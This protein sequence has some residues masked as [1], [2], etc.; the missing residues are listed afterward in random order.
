[1]KQ[2][3]LV[4]LL[5]IGLFGLFFSC[6]NDVALPEDPID[7]GEPCDSSIVY[8]ALDVLPIF[9]ANCAFSGCHDAQ[10][11]AEGVQ[12]DT[13]VNI[14]TTGDV[15]PNKPN[16]SKVYELIVA[17]SGNKMPPEPYQRLGAQQ[18]S[19]IE[20]WIN[21]GAKNLTCTATGSCDT[22][23]VSYATNITP[24]LS[25]SCLSCHAAAVYENVGGGIDLSSYNAVRTVALNGRLYGSVSHSPDYQAMP[26]GLSQ[27]PSCQI[28]QIKAWVDAGAP[29]N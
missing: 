14:M 16:K 4:L 21:Q 7:T 19:I 27:L 2:N 12:L 23:N 6:T 24:I 17:T 13:Y 15:Q 28:K 9:E 26:Q 5:L 18:I 25:S 22:T 3:S 11:R 20:N 8:F 10:T 29:N 1:M